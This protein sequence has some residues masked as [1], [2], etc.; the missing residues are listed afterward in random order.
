MPIGCKIPSNMIVTGFKI[1]LKPTKKQREILDQYFNTYRFCYNRAMEHQIQ[2]KLDFDSG[3]SRTSYM[4]K[5][6][7]TKII[8]DMRHSEDY[9]WLSDFDCTM[10]REA[11]FL[12]SDCISQAEKEH[13]LF[14]Y[15]FKKRKGDVYRSFASRPNRFK[16]YRRSVELTKIGRIRTER[17]QYYKGPDMVFKGIQV[18]FDHGE[19]FVTGGY[20][21]EKIQRPE[22]NVNDPIGIDFGTKRD[23]WFVDSHYRTIKRPNTDKI[24]K[25][26]SRSNARLA[27]KQIINNLKMFDSDSQV[28]QPL[29]LTNSRFPTKKEL[30]EM[31]RI[32]KLTRRKINIVK[33][34]MYKY[35]SDL[36]KENPSAIVIEDLRAMEMISAT[37]NS[38]MTK[39]GKAGFI[40]N[41]IESIPYKFRSHLKHQCDIH[42]IPLIRANKE[43]PSTQL[44]SVCG[45]RMTGNDRLKLADREF[46]CPVCGS[47]L[48]RDLNSSFNLKYLGWSFLKDPNFPESHLEFANDYSIV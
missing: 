35:V 30:K 25:Q 9:G 42:G 43:F 13:R 23:S 48:D 21:I 10:E 4:S 3:K 33:D 7:L 20:L 29:A 41:I 17:H 28:V 45:H 37:K 16:L 26:I 46:T 12:T 47:E 5:V 44:C 22:K 31:R 40:R 1:R 38:S 27:R 2:R 6:E 18:I 39:E 32:S 19:Y 34:V 11:M 24:S 15:Q 36:M 8:T 14:P